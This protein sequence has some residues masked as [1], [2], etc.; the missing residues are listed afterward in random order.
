MSSYNPSFLL[1]IICIIQ[2]CEHFENIGSMLHILQYTQQLNNSLFTRSLLQCCVLTFR[3]N[4]F[5]EMV[6]TIEV[7][8]IWKNEKNK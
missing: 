7:E 4:F 8:I 6:E 5:F 3:D 2:V 1:F